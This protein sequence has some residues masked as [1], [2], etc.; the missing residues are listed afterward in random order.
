MVCNLRVDPVNVLK[1]GIKWA[2]TFYV[3]LPGSGAFQ[4]LSDAITFIMAKEEVKL[5]IAT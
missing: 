1:F 2:N 5:H 3:D 4:I